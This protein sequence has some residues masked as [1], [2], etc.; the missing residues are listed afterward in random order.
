MKRN[1]FYLIGLTVILSVLINFGI[2]ALLSRGE[3]KIYVESN[4]PNLVP[5]NYLQR[6]AVN[7]DIT[8]SRET[9]ITR[10]VRKVSPAV[11]GINVTE[12]REYRD[13]FF[14]FLMIH[15]SEMTLSLEDFLEIEHTN[16]K[17]TV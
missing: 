17:C 7:Q 14:S 2:Q 15:F 12:I 16:K 13:P 9:A 10:T 1:Y 5:A 4:D 3:S 11:V 6:E 8:N